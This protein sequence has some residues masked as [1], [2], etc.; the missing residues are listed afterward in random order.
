MIQ[1]NL[2]CHTLFSTQL[3]M[4][5]QGVNFRVNLTY[6]SIGEAKRLVSGT[7][8]MPCERI[9]N[10]KSTVGCFFV[11]P[12]IPKNRPNIPPRSWRVNPRFS[13]GR[14]DSGSSNDDNSFC[15]GPLVDHAEKNDRGHLEKT[16][17]KTRKHC[18]EKSLKIA[19]GPQICVKV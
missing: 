5:L 16:N 8:L 12:V 1:W 18:Q 17:P 14:Q 10:K 13:S 7:P 3:H 11:I 19:I 9:P 6:P 4:S 2:F 15:K